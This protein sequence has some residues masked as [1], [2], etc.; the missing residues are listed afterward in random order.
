MKRYWI[1]FVLAALSALAVW[2]ARV[3]QKTVDGRTSDNPGLPSAGSVAQLHPRVHQRVQIYSDQ[4]VQSN[5]E[6]LALFQMDL[7]RMLANYQQQSNKV[8]A[9]AAAEAS[10]YGSCC[11]LIS[12][13]AWDAV[14]DQ[15]NAA[16]SLAAEVSPI[17]EP[18]LDKLND[19]IHT[20]LEKL[21]YDLKRNTTGLAHQLAE[22]RPNER[23]PVARNKNQSNQPLTL[24]PSLHNL[25]LNSVGLGIAI[26]FDTIAIG[27]S[28]LLKTA[29]THMVRIAGRAF[30]RQIAV[31]TGSLG[32]AAI[33]GPLP[34][35]DILAAGGLA[36]TAYDIHSSQQQFQSE[37]KVSLQTFFT[38]ARNES[39]QQ[40]IQHARALVDKHRE[41]QVAI[42][43]QTLAQYREENQR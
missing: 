40:A 29:Y 31:A 9:Q 18:L 8:A 6:A 16:D 10:D 14:S 41:Y 28:R 21:D 37:V 15:K 1:M 43:D 33:D 20:A 4:A 30:G 17:I 24:E 12:E 2:A 25:G 27:Q 5:L 19:D 26:G 3:E 42:A 35:G 13:I 23:E 22:L 39:H 11:M 38:E 32:A 7:Q 34:F 36:W